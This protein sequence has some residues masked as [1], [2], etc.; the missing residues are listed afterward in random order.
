MIKKIANLCITFSALL[1]AQS[2]WAQTSVAAENIIDTVI[3]SYLDDTK[4]TQ[5][6]DVTLIRDEHDIDQWYYVPSRPIL[7]TTKVGDKS[8]PQFTL[9]RYDYPDPI[10]PTTILRGG[11]LSFSARLSL[12]PEALNAM[13]IAA[14]DSIAKRKGRVVAEKIR[15]AALPINSATVSIYSADN[16]LVGAAEGTGTAPTFASQAMAFT[17][18]LTQLGTSVFEELIKSPTGV[19]TAVQFTYNGTT[20][21]CGYE[22]TADYLQVHNH[23]S[24]NEKFAARA[25]YYGLFSASVSKEAAEIREELT[26]SGALKIKMLASNQ[27]PS[28]R[29]DSLIQPILKRINDQVLDTLKP[30]EKIDPANVGTPSTGGFFGGAGYSVAL[31]KV[32]E[33]RRLNETF[34]FEQTNIVERST[35]AQG[36]IGIG[37]YPD[38]I[39]K[40]LILTIDGTINPGTYIAFPQIP[41]GISRVDLD[42]TLQAKGRSFGFGQYQYLRELNTW[43]NLQSG[44]TSDRISFSMAGIEQAYGKQ[45]INEAQVSI[46]KVLSTKDDYTKVVT[47]GSA[48]QGAASVELQDGLFGV[49]ISPSAIPFKEVGGDIVRV[50]V[51]AKSGSKNKYYNFQ[52]FNANG[53]WQSS[54]DAYFFSPER[55]APIELI[56]RFIHND[57]SKIVTRTHTVNASGMLDLFLEEFL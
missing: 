41:Q 23:Y 8:V 56:I 43:K 18:P 3:F 50:Q 45:G 30:P 4:T 21:K 51:I 28:E 14:I 57:K 2:T 40:D 54:S 15:I 34:S 42:I 6:A 12:P 19:R 46:S 47:V 10:N 33:L 52:A 44:R 16:N 55:D 9:L 11:L 25:S 7:V 37:N 17:L 35:V 22:V 38:S 39:K 32:S 5:N 1:T 48:S 53:V 20:P 27:C 49:R 26:K 24:K 13:K 29:L 31:K 36:F